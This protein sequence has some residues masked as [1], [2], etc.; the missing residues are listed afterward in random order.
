MQRLLECDLTKAKI[1]YKDNIDGYDSL[2]VV[3]FN[4]MTIEYYHDFYDCELFVNFTDNSRIEY[5]IERGNYRIKYWH[6][7]YTYVDKDNK[8]I[9]AWDGLSPIDT[10][11]KTAMKIKKLDNFVDNLIDVVKHWKEH[12]R[13]DRAA[14]LI[15][16]AFRGWKVRHAY[17]YD[18]GNCLGRHLVL[19]MFDDLLQKN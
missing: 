14:V 3:Q 5:S 15:Q 7:F 17:R 12:V 8:I 1:Q 2:Y 9:D 6:R 19:K 11:S 4:D 16:A 18:P 10:T 13:Q